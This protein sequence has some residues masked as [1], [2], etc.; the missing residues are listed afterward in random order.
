MAA[1]PVT[2]LERDAYI[3]KRLAKAISDAAKMEKALH[4][5]RILEKLRRE[6]ARQVEDDRREA[7]WAQRRSLGFADSKESDRYGGRSSRSKLIIAGSKGRGRG[8]NRDS[9]IYEFLDEDPL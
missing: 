6:T 3:A 5:A 9:V 1:R 7:E 4:D 2:E 8:G